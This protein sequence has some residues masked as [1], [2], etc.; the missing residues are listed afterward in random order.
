MGQERITRTLREH[1]AVLTETFAVHAADLERFARE[2]V[3]VFHRGGRLLVCGSGSLTAIAD[4]TANLFL[5]RL[6]LERPLLPALSLGHDMTLAT[7]LLRDGQGH[8]FFARQLRAVATGQDM[9]LAFAGGH[10]EESLETGLA[11]ARQLGCGTAMVLQG[12]GEWLRD[13]VD[14]LFRLETESVPRAVEGSLLFG[15]LL[16]ELVEGELFGI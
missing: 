15:H 3:N 5:H 14:F 10:R 7:S 8:E 1:T 2:M 9:V 12:K 4:L 13:S 11:A 6:S 16:A